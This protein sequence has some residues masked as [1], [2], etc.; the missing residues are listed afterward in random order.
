M[1]LTFQ[2]DSI[3]LSNLRQAVFNMY[4]TL[5]EDEF[6][7]E[8]TKAAGYRRSEVLK[9]SAASTESW[10]FVRASRNVCPFSNAYMLSCCARLV[11]RQS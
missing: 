11:N 10:T 6:I 7:E 2:E 9:M 5:I 4:S 8:L 1:D 3:L